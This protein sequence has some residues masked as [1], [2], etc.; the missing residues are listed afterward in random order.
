M[1][2]SERDPPLED[3]SFK[4]VLEELRFEGLS[5][6]KIAELVGSSQAY[7]T[8]LRKGERTEPS[9]RI[10]IRI[11]KLWAGLD[12]MNALKRRLRRAA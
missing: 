6:T 1:F 4:A 10:G 5:D 8:R 9:F 12:D 7:V 3:V 2:E 11:L